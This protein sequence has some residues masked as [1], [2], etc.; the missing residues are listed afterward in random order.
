LLSHFP[1]SFN[2]K[3]SIKVAEENLKLLEKLS[4]ELGEISAGML[5]G[6][7]IYTEKK[8][9][10]LLRGARVEGDD[11][12]YDGVM[13]SVNNDIYQALKLSEKIKILDKNS[14]NTGQSE[15]KGSDI[16]VLVFN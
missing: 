9:I 13:A 5:K 7:V 12:N 10:F 14:I 8:G 6:V 15:L 4:P 16:G 3:E 11:V 1:C 2:C